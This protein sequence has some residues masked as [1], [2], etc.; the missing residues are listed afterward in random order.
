MCSHLSKKTSARLLM[1]VT[2]I[3]LAA[4]GHLA[5]EAALDKSGSPNKGSYF[6]Q[7]LPGETPV[8]FAPEVLGSISPWVAATEF[9]PDGTLFFMGVGDATYSSAKLYYSRRVH[10]AWT[11]FAPAP[12]A[13]DFTMSHEAVFSADG[14][15]LTFTGTKANGSVD[16]WTVSY[17][18]QTWGTPVALPA[19]INTEAKEFRGSS[20]TDGTLYFGSERQP[21]GMMQVYKAHKDANQALV[22]ELVGPPV[23]T[24]NYDGDPCVAPDGRFLVFYSAIDRKSSDLYVSFNDG[25]GSWGKPIKLGPEFNTPDDEF[26]AH[27]SHDGKELF[28]TRHSKQ[29][30]KIYW[31]ATSAIDKLK[32]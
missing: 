31:V 21:A 18:N 5:G 8:L 4:C 26:G 6:G 10:D 14:R 3:F 13:S 12:F 9:S 24:N 2:T 17:L 25:K 15:S 28:F 11:P 27:L 23:S 30:D 1:G 32:P 20:M 19:T 16:L 7:N 22:V 29:G